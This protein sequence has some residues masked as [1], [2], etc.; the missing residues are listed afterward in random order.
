MARYTN[1]ERV[2]V[3][4]VER[5]I[6]KE[7]GWIFR[8]QPIVD[9]GIDAHM[10]LVLEG[11]P[12]GQ[13]V[14]LQIK[15][16][17]SHFQKSSGGYTYYGDVTHLEYWLNHS[18]PVVLVGHLPDTGETIWVQVTAD[19]VSRT[20][21]GWRITIPNKNR[22]NVEAGH[23]LA[24]V[25]DGTPAQQRYRRLTIDLPLMRHIKKSNKVSIEL[26]DWVNKSLGRTSIQVFLDDKPSDEHSDRD[27]TY[28]VGYGI[29]EL[30]EALYPWA[31]ASVDEGF[32]ESSYEF[33]RS[34][35]EPDPYEIEG[36]IIPSADPSDSVYPYAES[37]GGEVELYRLNLELNE[38]GES[39]LAVTD[40][41]DGKTEE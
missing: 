1:T 3:N 21:K 27:P 6:V 37:G 4:E 12:A 38:L 24:K 16:G 25:F 34:T 5:I 32:Y 22:L 23:E 19:A 28:F 8:E 20:K 18:L 14:A 39:F 30:A 36:E 9:M 31:I 2:G 35:Y 10:E 26:E 41:V 29:K 7:L 15:T 11:Q 13:L 40:Y 33:E 17:A